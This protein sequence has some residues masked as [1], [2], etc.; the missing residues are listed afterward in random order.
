MTVK[1]LIL[2]A[3]FCVTCLSFAAGQQFD[4]A[5]GVSGLQ[6]PSGAEASGNFSPQTIGGGAYPTFSGDFLF[7]KH[8][9][10]GGEV[11]WRASQN[12]YAG[13]QPFR[14]IFYTVNGVWA[15]QLAK[16]VSAEL[17]AGLGAENLRFYT[18]F[19]TC[20]SFSGCT[21]Y[22]STSHFMGHF[23]GG[24]RLY[25]THNLFVRPEAHLYLV[26]NNFEFS[27]SRATRYGLSIGY[28]WG[29]ER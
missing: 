17:L 10:V 12:L 24:L 18:G 3:A 26:H 9:G 7:W 22:V 15:P 1:R 25:V 14:P 19:V 8:F 28:S 20:G 29:G 4:A 27:G 16:R 11:S 6:G 13:V 5:F 2:I 21:N 23:G